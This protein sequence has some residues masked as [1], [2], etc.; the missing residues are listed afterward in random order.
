MNFIYIIQIKF[1]DQATHIFLATV[2]S[3]IAQQ[4]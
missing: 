2:I 3:K 4:N 1:N